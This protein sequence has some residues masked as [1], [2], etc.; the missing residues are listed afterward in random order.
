MKKEQ[1]EAASKLAADIAL[2]EDHDRHVNTIVTSGPAMTTDNYSV[3]HLYSSFVDWHEYKKRLNAKIKQLKVL[4]EA[5]SLIGIIGITGISAHAQQK[6]DNV[7]T[8]SGCS[9]DSVAEAYIR[10][11]FTPD[12]AYQAV[13]RSTHIFVL[14][15]RYQGLL[16]GPSCIRVTLIRKSDSVTWIYGYVGA[17]SAPDQAIRYLWPWKSEFIRLSAYAAGS[18]GK[19]GYAKTQ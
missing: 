7:I 2:Y 3:S 11:A 18:G 13:D 1:L 4:F 5:M 19:I 9:M 17:M 15:H 8:V 14:T 6:G 12:F 10:Q 16:A